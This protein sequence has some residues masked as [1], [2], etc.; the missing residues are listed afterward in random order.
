MNQRNLQI[1]QGRPS[2]AQN[3]SGGEVRIFIRIEDLCGIAICAGAV[4]DLVPANS[5]ASYIASTA[6]APSNDP[7]RSKVS[8]MI[9]SICPLWLN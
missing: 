1:A 9:M 7:A 4:S 8:V 2:R 3:M 6:E 5:E